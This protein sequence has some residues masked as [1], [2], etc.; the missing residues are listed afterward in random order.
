MRVLAVLLVILLASL[1][2]C[3]RTAPLVVPQTPL[4]DAVPA[5][6]TQPPAGASR[7]SP[8]PPNTMVQIDDMSLSITEVV[9]PA[10]SAVRNGSL[11]NPTPEPTANYIFVGLAATCNLP[12]E[13]SC[14]LG[15]LEF[16]LIDTAG[17]GHNPRLLI[18]GVPGKFEGSEFFGSATKQ[19]YLI[20][21]V[22]GVP[23]D[24][25]LKYEALFGGEAYLQ[26]N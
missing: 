9:F 2:A 3:G 20:F 26:L 10:D 16:S 18:A 19:G 8:A 22:D 15:G 11:W 13:S 7:F 12:V 1:L 25:V 4:A 21:V 6:P 17:I 5:A 14:R 23:A 24:Y